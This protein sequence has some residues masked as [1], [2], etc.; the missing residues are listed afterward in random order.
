MALNFL[1]SRSKHWQSQVLA[2]SALQQQGI[3]DIWQAVIQYREK[4]GGEIEQRRS[5][6]AINWLWAE[7]ADRLLDD[8]RGDNRVQKLVSKLQAD[9]IAGKLPPTVAAEKLVNTFRQTGE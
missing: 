4:L 2:L 5:A 1:H 9:V 8:L 3:S 6:Q 7:T